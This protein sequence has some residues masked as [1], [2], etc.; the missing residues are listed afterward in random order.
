MGIM[1]L[2]AK[3][4]F[5]MR[6]TVYS[7][8]FTLTGGDLVVAS[9]ADL[10][11]LHPFWRVFPGLSIMLSRCIVATCAAKVGMVGQSKD[12]LNLCVT[13]LAFLERLWWFRV[14][15]PMAGNAGLCR[16]MGI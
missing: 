11:V 15:R 13:G 8:N 2:P 1:T 10:P 14:M 6:S 9:Q 3:I 5:A 4:L 7:G 12:A 16:I